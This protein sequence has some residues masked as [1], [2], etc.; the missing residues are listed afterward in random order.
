MTDAFD[1][2]SRAILGLPEGNTPVIPDLIN[3]NMAETC[4]CFLDALAKSPSQ[5]A[6]SLSTEIYCLTNISKAKQWNKTD[7]KLTAICNAVA[8]ETGRGIN[9]SNK[10]IRSFNNSF[11]P[12]ITALNAQEIC[13]GLPGRMNTFSLRLCITMQQAVRSGMTSYWLMWE[14]IS[15]YPGFNWGDAA[16]MIPQDFAKYAEAVALVGMNQYYGF[17]QDLGAAK[18]TNYLSLSWL[19][20][21]L[22]MKCDPPGYASLSQYRG[23]PA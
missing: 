11:K 14:A 1:E 18:L 13:E 16:I 19:S 12:Y 23:I 5:S 6:L 3:Q 21:K 17:N 20:C 15:T 22:L 10:D 8:E 7:N 2:T 4:A 9:L